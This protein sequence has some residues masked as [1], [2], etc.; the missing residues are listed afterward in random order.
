LKPAP[1]LA[2]RGDLTPCNRSTGRAYLDARIA[3]A[4]RGR[5]TARVGA[6]QKVGTGEGANPSPLTHL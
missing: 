4:L 5:G 3:V 2:P 6:R 1:L